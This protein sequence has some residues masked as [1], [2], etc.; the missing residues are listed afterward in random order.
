MRIVIFTPRRYDNWSLDVEIYIPVGRNQD[1]L[2]EPVE[3][4]IN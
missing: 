1:F 3:E 4:P 2:L